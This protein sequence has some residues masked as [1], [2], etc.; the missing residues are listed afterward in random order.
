MNLSGQIIAETQDYLGV[1][2]D[3]EKILMIQSALLNAGW[4]IDDFEPKHNSSQ[5]QHPTK[6][7]KGRTKTITRVYF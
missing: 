2:L 7:A 5:Y 1:F 3:C 4:L 6:K